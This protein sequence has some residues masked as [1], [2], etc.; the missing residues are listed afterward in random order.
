MLPKKFQ[1]RGIHLHP[2]ANV[3]HISKDESC[4]IKEKNGGHLKPGNT[5]VGDTKFQI[6]G[7]QKKDFYVFS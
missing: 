3:D 1:L 7:L 6:S 4:S 2:H 5:V